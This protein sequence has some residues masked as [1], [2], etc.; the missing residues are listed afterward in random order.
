[1]SIRHKGK[2]IAA[3]SGLVNAW[4]K[5]KG[6][7]TDQTDLVEFVSERLKS[8]W[9]SFTGNIQEQKDLIQYIDN[10]LSNLSNNNVYANFEHYGFDMV[11]TPTLHENVVHGFSKD[12]YVKTNVNIPFGSSW[13]I[14]FKLSGTVRYSDTTNYVIF[15]N[16]ENAYRTP[17]LAISNGNIVFWLSSNGKA[18]DISAGKRGFHTYTGHE[19]IKFSYDGVTYQIAY[20]DNGLDW[21]VDVSYDAKLDVYKEETAP[22]SF[23]YSLGGY[24]A[25][26]NIGIDLAKTYIILDGKPYWTAIEQIGYINGTTGYAPSGFIAADTIN[27]ATTDEL[28]IVK[29]GDSL[30]I[31]DDGKLDINLADL[32]WIDK[33]YSLME[34][35][36]IKEGQRQVTLQEFLPIDDYDYECIIKFNGMIKD[37]MEET[38]KVSVSSSFISEPIDLA[39]AYANDGDRMCGHCRVIVG[40]DRRLNIDV[41]G[42]VLIESLKVVAYRRHALNT[43]DES[44]PY[45]NFEYFGVN[46]DGTTIEH[47]ENENYYNNISTSKFVTTNVPVVLKGN[48]EIGFKTYNNTTNYSASN[49]YSRHY[50]LI[51]VGSNIYSN[52]SDVYYLPYISFRRDAYMKVFLGLSSNGTSWDI[53][54]INYTGDYQYF[55]GDNYFRLKHF[56]QEYILEHSKDSVN[57]SVLIQVSSDLEIINDDL[58]ELAFLNARESL[59]Y[60]ENGYSQYYY[61]DSRDRIYANDT[62]IVSDGKPFWAMSENIEYPRKD[63]SIGKSI[64][65]SISCDETQNNLILGSF[66]EKNY[67]K[68]NIVPDLGKV[69][70]IHSKFRLFPTSSVR[71]NYET[72]IF[73]SESTTERDTLPMLNYLESFKRFRVGIPFS[74]GMRRYLTDEIPENNITDIHIRL[75]RDNTLYS[76]EYE[77]ENGWV[78]FWNITSDKN[79]IANNEHLAFG[80]YDAVL[81]E[82]NDIYMSWSNTDSSFKKSYLYN[83]KLFILKDNKLYWSA[84]DREF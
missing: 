44:E 63:Y 83:D 72:P 68:T 1:M 3:S 34:N 67:I 65:G 71:D 28:G 26:G 40:T 47:N 15:G 62:Y 23:G 74:D 77:T 80:K 18:W 75:K 24:T 36:I 59:P 11:G 27:K 56:N 64:V 84:V 22:L 7:I 21:N 35:Y 45:T 60:L 52:Q 78:S 70:E 50:P 81:A 5:I 49:S 2:V 16:M 20:S 32:K 17:M 57:W 8:A 41:D 38:C 48:W 25:L 39:Y 76:L 9:G 58:H 29:V 33:S 46:L 10:R 55:L 42:H 79:L 13:K 61:V 51:G 69:W 66:N 14:I 31:D 82:D 6:I 12:N 37:T 30:K 43:I 54:N 73:I 53:A 19:Y 4:G